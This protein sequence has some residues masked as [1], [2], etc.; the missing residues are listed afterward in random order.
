MSSS[1]EERKARQAKR[2]AIIEENRAELNRIAAQMNEPEEEDD[3]EEAPLTLHYGHCILALPWKDFGLTDRLVRLQTASG[4]APEA[5]QKRAQLAGF[6]SSLKA[7]D[8]DSL[9]ICAW[10]RL[11]LGDPLRDASVTAIVDTLRF[12]GESKEALI[13]NLNTE[14]DVLYEPDY[15]T[16]AVCEVQAE[17]EHGLQPYFVALVFDETGFPR[18]VEFLENIEKE[19]LAAALTKL[20]SRFDIERAVVVAQ[21]AAPAI[22]RRL[23]A[24]GMT[25]KTPKVTDDPVEDFELATARRY[26]DCFRVMGRHLVV[27]VEKK[28]DTVLLTGHVVSC[29][30]A[31]LLMHQLQQRI[32]LNGTIYNLTELCN[33]LADAELITFKFPKGERLYQAI[34]RPRRR[35]VC[36]GFVKERFSPSNDFQL[37]KAY[38]LPPMRG[39]CQLASLNKSLGTDFEDDKSAVPVP[40]ALPL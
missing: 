18:D 14:C 38:K 27:P 13:A 15:V 25:V 29:L 37:L 16:M 10:N 20:Q 22:R 35:P 1:I 23:T 3:L 31:L 5:A 7:M 24:L 26:G 17:N 8:P 34:K 36:C 4:V 19:T 40:R 33:A 6:V 21:K 28:P 32:A 12:L 11:F 2:R 30:L 9:D 39:M